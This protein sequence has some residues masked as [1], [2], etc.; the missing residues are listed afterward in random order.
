MGILVDSGTKVICQ[1]LT[2]ATA[3]RLSERALAYGTKLVGGVAI[4]KVG[5]ATEVE[6]KEKKNRVEGDEDVG[7][8][9]VA[10]GVYVSPPTPSK[11]PSAP[12]YSYAINL[13]HTQ[14]NLMPLF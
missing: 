5:G 9:W 11:S 1:G 14:T 3:P 12:H 13:H 7:C 4:I 10:V 8:G 2:G 6:L